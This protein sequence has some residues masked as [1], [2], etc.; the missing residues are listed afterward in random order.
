LYFDAALAP[1]NF[2]VAGFDIRREE[3]ND[4]D[5]ATNDDRRCSRRL[6]QDHRN[7]ADG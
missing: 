5:F 1:H 6:H 2:E 3:M 4:P 7:R